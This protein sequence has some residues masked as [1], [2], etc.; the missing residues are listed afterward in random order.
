[1]NKTIGMP[2]IPQ[3]ANP[4]LTRQTSQNAG[5]RLSDTSS[6]AIAQKSLE[7]EMAR[8]EERK[9]TGGIFERISS[10][11]AVD[12]GSAVKESRVYNENLASSRPSFPSLQRS[13]STYFEEVQ[14][15]FSSEEISNIL[16]ELKSGNIRQKSLENRI[17]TLEQEISRLQAENRLLRNSRGIE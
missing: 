3:Y 5:R 12:S 16:Q 9:K 14:D 15:V 13:E 10:T 8:I 17:H 1:M 4:S 7:R 11:K 6:Y 2:P